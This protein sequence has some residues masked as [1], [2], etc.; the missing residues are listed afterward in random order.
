MNCLIVDDEPF[1]LDLL[2]DNVSKVPYLSL[3]KKCKN[4][5]E[6]MEAM[7][8]SK[9]DLIFLDIQMSG[10]TG[11][12]FLKTLN[13]AKPM[14][15]FVTAYEKYA[16]EGYDLN[17]LDY[18]VKPVSLERFVKACNKAKTSFEL[19]V[20]SEELREIAPLS[21]LNSQ[22][23]T[24]SDFFFVNADHGHTKITISDITHIEGMKD[25]I[26]IFLSSQSKAIITRLSIK[27]MEEKLGA[28]NFMRVHKSYL[29]ATNK[30]EFVR[31]QRIHIG[32]YVIPVSDNFKD[33]IALWIEKN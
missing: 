21:T 3:I 20:K 23:S 11:I 18:L 8:I 6:A 12:Q 30:I 29:V 31:N 4:A 14:V 22:L 24:D 33:E 25:Y 10:L 32:T 9:I 2:E 17:I 5:F 7:Q 19:R 26:K 28:T 16:L 1:A 13:D 27:A 15:I